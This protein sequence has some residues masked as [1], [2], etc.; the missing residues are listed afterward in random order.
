[1][2]EYMRR[3]VGGTY[4][5]QHAPGAELRLHWARD[6]DGGFA[7]HHSQ[8][9]LAVLDHVELDGDDA[10]NL[11]GA[12]EGDLAVTLR[13]VQIA[14]AELR[15]FDVHGKVHFA[16][17]GEVLDIACV[18]LG[19]VGGGKWWRAYSCHRARGGQGWSAHLPYLL[20]P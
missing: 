20:S 18:E 3:R 2:F 5:V 13:E 9:G 4:E 8:L 19:D 12:A 16:A 7:A 1:M 10:G 17:A 6:V 11:D 15:A 14:D